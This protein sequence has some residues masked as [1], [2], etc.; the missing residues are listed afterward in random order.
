MF[1]TTVPNRN[2][3]PAVLLRESYRA[4]GKVKSRTLANLSSWPAEKVETLRAVLRGDKLVP[5]GEGGFE[6]RRSL[7][8]GH[9]LAALATARRIGLDGLLPRRAPRRRRDLALALIIARLLDP[10]AKLATARMLDPATASHSLGETLGLGAVPVREVYAAL[11]WLG[12]EQTFIENGLARRHLKEGALVLYDVTSTYLEGR[13]CELARHGYSRDKRGDRPQLVIGLL[14][15]A[16]GCPVAVEVFAGNT[17]DPATL[18]AQIGKLKDRFNLKRVVMVGDRGMITTARIEETLRPAGLDWITALRAPAIKDLAVDGGPLQPSLF[19]DRDMAEISSPDFPGERLV[20]CKNPL[21]AEDRARTREELLAA[22]EMDLA[23]IKARV[24]RTKNPLRGAA[25]IGR[26][27]GAVI[28][29]RKMAKHFEI[30]ITDATFGFSRKQEQIDA[31]ARLDGIYVLRTNLTAEQSDA[32]ATVRAYK[33][34]AQVERAFRCM[35]T[36]DLDIRPV[37]HWTAPRVRAHVLLCML[38]YHLEWH[39]R[40]T[41]APVLF[42]DEDKVAAEAR[43]AS[44]VAKAV[45]SKAA[46]TKARA[47]LTDPAHGEALPVHSFRTLLADLATLTRNTICFGGKSLVTVLAKPTAVQ[48]R[49]LQLLGAELGV[50]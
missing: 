12:S 46:E 39:M 22:T 25:E 8:H 14:C 13:H 50:A 16:D 20:V 23:R 49:A 44:P 2:S 31:E 27:V 35:K 15:A 19:D 38:A 28:G 33:G 45:I 3:P 26:A 36:V 42:D 47:R 7:P 18:A 34:L 30:A 43:R 6:I 11:D 9:V 4:D 48:T 41:L 40:R 21:L 32:A 37:F 5:A 24:E 29:K 1:V 17:A 10:A